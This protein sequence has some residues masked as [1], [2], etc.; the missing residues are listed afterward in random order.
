MRAQYDTLVLTRLA[1]ERHLLA[2]VIDLLTSVG[3]QLTGK[4]WHDVVALAQSLRGN[5]H[6]DI[7]Q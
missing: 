5:L 1:L 6:T 3:Y 2:I 4:L 7:A